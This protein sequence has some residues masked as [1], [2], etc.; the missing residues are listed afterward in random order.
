VLPRAPAAASEDGAYRIG[1]SRTRFEQLL[2]PGV[3]EATVLALDAHTHA[4]AGRC[5]GHEDDAP[6]GG[7][8]YP[9]T[10]RGELVD[11]ER[12]RRC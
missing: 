10:T 5:E 3:Q 4:V 7:A 6:V 12:A 9:I 1:S 2:D 8:P 11:A